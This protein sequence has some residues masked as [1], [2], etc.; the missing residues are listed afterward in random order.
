M[1]VTVKL[2]A[3][4]RQYLPSGHDGLAA[5]L[6]VPDGATAGAVLADL[7][8]PLEE[9]RLAL[10]NG[11]TDTDATGWLGRPLKPNDTLA[12]LPRIH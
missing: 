11:V 9:C 10:I 12:A 3:H 4:F 8:V 7:G 6:E 5:V 1:K 2:L